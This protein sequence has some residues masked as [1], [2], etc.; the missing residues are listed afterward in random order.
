MGT[1]SEPFLSRR[2]WDTWLRDVYTYRQDAL[3]KELSEIVAV[4]N[5]LR[6]IVDKAESTAAT[7]ERITNSRLVKVG[8]WFTGGMVIATL[9]LVVVTAIQ[10]MK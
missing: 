3:Q 1:E 7:A 9:M 6:S 5:S 8:V 10:V 4:L 2:E